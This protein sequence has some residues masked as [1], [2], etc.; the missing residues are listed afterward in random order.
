MTPSVSGPVNAVSSEPVTNAKF[1]TTLGKVLSRPTL[2]PVPA[3]MAKLI[4]GE[5]AD[6]LLLSS[7]RVKP[8]KLVSSGFEFQHNNLE[9]ALRHLLGKTK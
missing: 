2:I 3:F 9:L 1:T 5:M 4:L 7:S 8:E 6:E